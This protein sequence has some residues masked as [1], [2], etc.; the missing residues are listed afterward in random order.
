[1]E[2]HKE[3]INDNSHITQ[4]SKQIEVLK[5]YFPQCFDK[6]GKFI[7][8][9]INE[10]VGQSG[11]EL[12]QESYN[13]NWLGK[14]YARLLANE[15]P[16]TL[17]KE[18]KEHNL[19]EKNNN[20]Q[21]ILVK[22]DNL[23]VLK[24]LKNAY[25]ESIKM[26]YVDPPYNTGNDEFVYKDDRKFTLEELSQLAGLSLDEAKRILDFTASKSNSHSAWLTFMY[27]RLYIAKELLK[28][29]GMIFI[30][31]DDN[32]VAQ[33][34]LLCNEVFGE[35]NF[36]AQLPTIMNL[37]G[38]NDEFGFAGT[39]EFTMVYAKKKISTLLGEFSIDEDEIED[40]MEDALGYYKQGANLKSTGKNAPR[41]K[42]PNLYF[43]V[44]IDSND[45]IYITDDDNAP[46]DFYGELLTLYPITNE[47]QMSWRWSKDKF[48]KESE[49]VIVS[50]N[51]S[52]GI[53]KKQRPALGDMPSKKPK[54][55]FYKPNYSSGNGTAQIK[56]LFNEVIFPNPKPLDL[57]YDFMQLGLNN[58]D[59]VLDLFAGSGTT[60]QAV[61][62]LNMRDNG[63]RKFISIQIPEP[64]DSKKNKL[65]YDFV[66][67]ELGK[68]KPTIFDITK[69]R[70][71]RAI[72][73]IEEK[74]T[75]FRGDL[76][77]KVFETVPIFNGLIENIKEL[78]D[79]AKPH[80]FDIESLS[81]DDVDVLLTT[82]K[83]FDG[84]ELTQELEQIY[85]GEYK[86]FYGNK[87]LYCLYNGFKPE[88]LRVLLKKL[89]D[90]RKFVP[91]KIIL[92]GYNFESARQREIKEALINYANKKNIEI[93]M[94]VRY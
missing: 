88:N 73:K 71:V 52:A 43:P 10:I 23:E 48:R 30:S 12:S 34:K 27:P 38:N 86:A 9:K 29:A 45:K 81:D 89:D 53:Y 20:S 1:M 55:I 64:I 51:G 35:E 92:F 84:I 37:K 13:L 66:K 67:N 40:W 82:Y 80:L 49:G 93:D 39:H 90:D 26:I 3:K 47:K 8:R 18:D 62:E 15:D 58:N 72:K 91:S 7:S 44:F 24:H 33:L 25:K 32:E 60:A 2:M 79:D 31:I 87:K 68:V 63:N 5:Q 41:E 50:R 46:K 16:F 42:R 36:I 65:A 77:F 22:G 74:N 85:L 28:D 6:D 75:E 57:I 83:V 11:L 70:I 14:S 76:G 59:T 21:N 19:K 54:T 4:N 69:E 17:L 94:V 56:E 61:M 78:K